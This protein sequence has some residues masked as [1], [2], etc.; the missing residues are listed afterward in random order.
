MS[1][2]IGAIYT[3]IEA[4][5]VLAGEKTPTVYGLTGL[6]NTVASANL[7]CRIL[8]DLA[9]AGEGQSMEFFS[10]NS[11]ISGGGA[12]YVDWQ[13]S[14]LLLY[15]PQAQGLGVKQVA[16][17][18]VDY[19]GAY[20]DACRSNRGLVN[21]ATNEA[22]VTGLRVAPGIYEYP[23]SSGNFY[24]GCMATLTIREIIT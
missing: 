10:I 19:T 13:L 4:M 11:G 1:S 6:P 2:A 12:Q 14:D 16:V 17:A 23:V 3:A 18:L 15:L 21:T 7:P 9:N 22:N 20:V 8:L 24:W 5:S